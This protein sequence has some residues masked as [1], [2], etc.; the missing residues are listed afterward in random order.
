MRLPV[1][2]ITA[3]SAPA[4][5][6]DACKDSGF[7]YVVE[8]EVDRALSTRLEILSREF[9]AKPSSEKLAKTES[10]DAIVRLGRRPS[11]PPFCHRGTEAQSLEGSPT[12]GGVIVPLSTPIT[13]GT[14]AQRDLF[15]CKP[16]VAICYPDANCQMCSQPRS[17]LWTLV[18]LCDRCGERHV[19]A[20]VESTAYRSLCLSASVAKRR[21]LR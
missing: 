1:I 17:S 8:H 6:R 21:P 10:F 15:L 5:I 12:G 9:F 14:R 19:G 20:G 2:D 13:E 4:A 11:G 3:S 16:C 18:L 7:F